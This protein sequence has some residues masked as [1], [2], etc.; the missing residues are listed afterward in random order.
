MR[1]GIFNCNGIS[2]KADL[3]F[4][5][6]EENN[7]DY[8]MLL[9][10]WLRET[11]T[12]R[13]L[14]SPFVNLTKPDNRSIVGGRRA[15]GGIA[16]YK[17]NNF[18][19]KPRIIHSDIEA[20]YTI[21]MVGQITMG[22]GY[23]PPRENYDIKLITFL[24]KVVELS[25]D[26][27]VIIGGD[28]N[29][30]A[31]EFGDHT[32]NA[33]GRKLVE[34]YDNINNRIQHRPPDS[35][36]FTSFHRN[37]AGVTDLIF[38][39]NIVI[40]DLTIDTDNMGGSDHLPM[41]LTID[42]V[43]P[44][45]RSFERWDVRKL[46]RAE[47]RQQFTTYL[48][49]NKQ[50]VLDNMQQVSV[51]EAW[52]VVKEYIEAAA[53]QSCGIFQYKSRL[54]SDFWTREMLNVRDKLSEMTTNFST[55]LNFS[56]HLRGAVHAEMV[57]LAQE[58]RKLTHDRRR[59]LYLEAVNDLT[60]PQNRASFLRMVKGRSNSQKGKHCALDPE[61]MEV[62]TAHFETTFGK[63][64]DYE[65]YIPY[66]VPMA[67]EN[68]FSEMEIFKVLTE[69]P[70]GKAA[71]VDK[72]VGEFFKYGAEELVNIIQVLFN[73]IY[74]TNGIIPD[75]WRRAIIVP[76][77]KKK[78]SDK[79]A[80]NYRPIAMTCVCR[81]LYEKA[82]RTRLDDAVNMLS[83][84]QGGFRANRST[85]DQV[86]CLMEV[87]QKE[88]GLHN[89]YLDLMAAY[90]LVERT[91]LWEKLAN[92]FNIPVELIIRL[93]QLFDYNES[94][95]VVNNKMSEPVAN[96]RG[97][98]QGSSL[99]PILFNF[100][101][102]DLIVRI[103]NNRFFF[104]DDG[105]IH[106]REID[107]L[108]QTLTIC[109]N[110]SRENGMMFA[111]TKC[112]YVGN[113][114]GF[115]DGE[116]VTIPELRLYDTALPKVESTAYLGVIFDENGF[117][118]EKHFAERTKKADKMT[119]V[120]AEIGMNAYGWPMAASAAVY[121]LFIRPRMEYGLALK[122]LTQS[123]IYMLQKTQNKAMRK[124]CGVPNNAS[125][126]AMQKLLR[127]VPMK[128]RNQI[129]HAKFYGKLKN[130]RDKNIPATTM[131]NSNQQKK[132][133]VA[134]KVVK[135]PLWSKLQLRNPL[136]EPYQT[137]NEPE[138]LRKEALSNTVQKQVELDAIIS[139][140]G[141]VASGITVPSLKLPKWCNPLRDLGKKTLT[142][143]SR[144]S[145]GSVCMHQPCMKCRDGTELSRE[146]GILCSG[147]DIMMMCFFP[148]DAA[149]FN[150]GGGNII[151]FILN[152][153]I[154]HG[155]IMDYEK[156]ATA[157]ERILKDCRH[158][159]VE[160][161]GK[162]N[163]LDEPAT[164]P[165]PIV[166]APLTGDQSSNPELTARRNR[167]STALNLRRYR[168]RMFHNTPIQ[169]ITLEAIR[170]NERFNV[171]VNRPSITPEVTHSSGT[172]ESCWD[173]SEGVG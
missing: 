8:M 60:L 27:P 138:V 1:I 123:Q 159:R 103:R 117:N 66:D 55:M 109:E 137:H 141:S 31:V 172:T 12:N 54:N 164:N 107:E 82:L 38:Y 70:L 101:I 25:C 76:I 39:A 59:V 155:S 92:R 122:L 3:I 18:I 91:L 22:V 67:T 19:E 128:T 44:P 170:A 21:M 13:G 97:L 132:N 168:P 23:F 17:F 11:S 75:E 98:L 61:Q 126:N 166:T 149:A 165:A 150:E 119:H 161:T 53:R 50:Q 131:F 79:E 81:R 94:V 169:D 64:S 143:L 129:L 49:Q 24:E 4:K 5:Y 15:I 74:Y 58:L 7:V 105:N 34:W 51:N 48:S 93:Q 108:Q 29:A 115:I 90:D 145:C 2:G 95:L 16:G 87:M 171:I 135:N 88:N 110:W 112:F 102:D 28:F 148:S 30:R 116:N 80:K 37:G 89:I 68:T 134:A 84:F 46:A 127:I 83:P 104:A 71:G 52:N 162:W 85:L 111:A 99:S 86:Y 100:F 6:C 65:P 125:T 133:T 160:D 120:L 56:N 106:A 20:N 14:G 154:E 10:T 156:V 136:F 157:I 72:L 69:A 9:E 35:G 32:N 78:G 62:H 140:T 153:K 41:I 124:I 139:L 40:Q 36:K 73:K 173:E 130:S 144:W 33:R 43:I 113:D 77:Y 96:T 163:S 63:S 152:R 26:G 146:H 47:V 147:A 167:I 142:L 151:D 45:E 114:E 57:K 121:K 42:H 118:V 158:I